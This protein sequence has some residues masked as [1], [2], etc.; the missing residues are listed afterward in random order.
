MERNDKM[1]RY[2][3]R[4]I[5]RARRSALFFI[6]IL[7][8][9]TSCAIPVRQAYKVD[10]SLPIG[11]IRGDS[12]VG[13]RF[14]FKIKI[15]AGWQATTQYP[16]FLVEQGY[17]REGLKETPFFLFNPQTKSSLQVDFS[18]AG[19]TVRFSQETIEA[20]VRMSGA[21]LA[22]EIHEE[23]GQGTPINLSKVV[24][25]R[26]K[27]VPYAARMW[28]EL[29]VKG[30]PREQGWIYA[31]AEPFQIFILYLVAGENRAADKEA[32]EQALSSFEYLGVCPPDCPHK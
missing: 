23:H 27:G 30:E 31:F 21:G 28:A 25:I 32:L 3:W 14:P 29:T 2:N 6:L 1:E 9:A 8:V 4:L 20:M 15:P 10:E 13:Q 11:S 18:P 7:P 24:P 17:G 5:F 22:S 19:R 26:L 12:F 16:E